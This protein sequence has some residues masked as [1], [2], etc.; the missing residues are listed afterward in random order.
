ME[1]NKHKVIKDFIACTQSFPIHPQWLILKQHKSLLRDL[2]K[3]VKDNFVVLDIGCSDK[4]IGD[5]IETKAYYIGLD[6]YDTATNWYQTRPNVYGDA[7]ML[8]IASES[9][10]VVYLMDVAEHL[11]CPEQALKE[12]ARVLKPSG[13]LILTMPFVYPIHDAPMDFQRWTE[14]GLKQRITS[15]GLCCVDIEGHGNLVS[16]GCLLIN[17][18]IARTFANMIAKKH[19]GL[20]LMPLAVV[21]VIAINILGYI[22]ELIFKD[23]DV[24]PYGYRVVANKT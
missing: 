15:C 11:T 17:L 3:F 2:T 8:G 19:L 23:D 24:A 1:E 12:I 9:I 5:L 14:Y 6:Y 16:S 7:Q 20:L 18:G 13:T 22:A 21:A 10:D 4:A